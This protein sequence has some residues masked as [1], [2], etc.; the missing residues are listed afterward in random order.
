MFGGL[1][2]ILVVG[3]VVVRILSK[4]LGWLFRP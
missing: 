3:Y 2:V 1:V 4:L